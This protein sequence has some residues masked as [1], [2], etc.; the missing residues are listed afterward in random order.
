MKH[1]KD[2][3]A[4]NL[5]DTDE[6]LIVEDEAPGKMK[7]SSN[8]FP[9]KA[10]ISLVISGIIIVGM[11]IVF[12]IYFAKYSTIPSI[13][14]VV[15]LLAVLLTI[16]MLLGINYLI[17]TKEYKFEKLYL[18]LAIPL[19]IIMNLVIIPG[20]VPDEGTH[21]EF[22]YSLSSQ[23]MGVEEN[24]KVTL[25]SEEKYIYNNLPSGPDLLK[26]EYTYSHLLSG[27]DNGAYVQVDKEST[28]IKEAFGYLPAIAGT[29]IGRVLHIGATPTFYLARIFNTIISI[30]V[31]YF[32]I[33]RTPIGK[34]LM[35][36]IAL[37]P[38]TLQ[39]I[40]SLSYDSMLIASSLF[41]VAYGLRFVYDN[42]DVDGGNFI[43]FL[44]SGVVLIAL[45]SSIYAFILMIPIFAKF[46]VLDDNRRIEKRQKL[47]IFLSIGIVI[48]LLNFMQ[49]GQSPVT[50]TSAN[51]T[52]KN[53]ISWSG[54]EG[55]TVSWILSHI[56]DSINIFINS[57][58]E[59][60][61]FYLFS[62][63]GTRLSWFTITLSDTIGYWWLGFLVVG[64]LKSEK[65]EYHIEARLKILFFLISAAGIG[66]SM[67]AMWIYWT[68][69]D[70][71]IILG[72]QGRYFIPVFFTLF[73]LLNNKY[74]KIK[75]SAYRYINIAMII[76]IVSTM[77]SLIN[78]CYG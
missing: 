61:N 35:L 17:L 23:L 66:L 51:E 60:F 43:K 55:Y 7:H 57:L 49:F 26:Y 38:I 18:M 25:R 36:T 8:R 41:C 45:K 62:A 31:I 13:Y 2:R 30:W 52:A 46:K 32:A 16:A 47:I 15:K 73:M 65:S 58:S 14:W 27:E 59:N 34:P 12:N 54:T 53:I 4:I 74:I 40:C 22:T 78:I 67:L 6:V 50:T 3:E 5:E 70:S 77:T 56:T 29:T 24:G 28:G 48:L 1:K 71:P 76:L 9:I 69:L 68:P 19:C 42:K 10:I 20:M 37:L 39:Q 75:S 64:A 63:V 11:V 33:K 72:V 44:A 21:M